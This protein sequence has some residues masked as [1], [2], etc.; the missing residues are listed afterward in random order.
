MQEVTDK[1]FILRNVDEADR[2]QI[3]QLRSRYAEVK[4][5]NQ[6][7]NFNTELVQASIGM[8]DMAYD[9]PN[10]RDAYPAVQQFFSSIYKV[11]PH[12]I[13]PRQSKLSV[14]IRGH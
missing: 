8:L 11:S 12:E 10:P 7:N 14:N 5:Q 2:R 4:V 3:G 1:G 13:P 9:S 6:G